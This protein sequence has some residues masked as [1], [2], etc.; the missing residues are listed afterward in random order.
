M[1]LKY[2]EFSTEISGIIVLLIE[3]SIINRNYTYEPYFQDTEAEVLTSKL[4]DIPQLDSSDH[5]QVS[6][7][8]KSN[9]V[10]AVTITFAPI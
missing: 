2:L 5:T 6:G 7:W 3:K 1:G 10:V 9:C 4:P 8:C